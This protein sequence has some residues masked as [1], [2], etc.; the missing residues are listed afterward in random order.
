MSKPDASHFKY[1]KTLR[2]AK[3]IAASEPIKEI[4]TEPTGLTSLTLVTLFS[5]SWPA[6]PSDL[7]VK[8]SE[9]PPRNTP[10]DAEKRLSVCDAKYR[11]LYIKRPDAVRVRKAPKTNRPAITLFL[12]IYPKDLEGEI[13][14]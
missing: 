1:S 6:S 8:N 10:M 14:T 5:A 12:I 2:P 9:M 7:K 11:A 13:N 4:I 3:W